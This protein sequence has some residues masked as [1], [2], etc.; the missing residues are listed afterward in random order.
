[1]SIR[2]VASQVFIPAAVLALTV[3]CSN[4]P[5]SPSTTVT[6]NST[7]SLDGWVQSDGV[8]VAS[9]GGPLVGDF[10]DVSP[11]IG[12]RQFYSF[13]ISTI[14]AGAQIVSAT[15][16]LYQAQS[17]G[18]PFTKL[19]NVVVDRIDIGPALDAADYASLALTSNI[20]TL[21]TNS[22]IEYKVLDVTNAV[23][24]DRS[25]ARNKSEFRLRFSTAYKWGDTVRDFVSFTDAEDSC[26]AVSR[27]PQLVIEYKT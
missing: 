23:K 24:S 16:R 6:L 27:P 13:D 19:G 25:A 20:G 11:N 8:A 14:P 17:V 2:A 12:Y 7:A 18:S 22:T 5:A 1:M 9:Q 10:E 4:N 3:S 15:L 26:C 21:S